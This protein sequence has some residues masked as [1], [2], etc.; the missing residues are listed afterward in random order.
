ME[1]LFSH[2]IL[3]CGTLCTNKTYLPKNLSKD[4][5]LKRGEY[6]YR[7]SKD[8]IVVYKWRDNKV[9]HAISNF[10]GTEQSQV[11]RKNKDGTISQVACPEAI[12]HYNTYMGGVD[13]S[14]IVLCMGHPASQRCGGTE[15]FLALLIHL[16]ATQLL[17]IK[18]V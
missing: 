11:N 4:S 18:S 3:C 8:D 6:D 2:K 17:C 9:I 13:K 15:S 10:H 16:C 5:D 1:Y 7:V 12:K 14:D